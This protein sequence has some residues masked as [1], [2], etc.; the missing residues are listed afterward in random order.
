MGTVDVEGAEPME[1]VIVVSNGLLLVLV[2][3]LILVLLF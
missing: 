1:R 2:S 3:V